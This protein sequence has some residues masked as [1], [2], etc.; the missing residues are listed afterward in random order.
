MIGIRITALTTGAAA[1]DTPINTGVID[2]GAAR[3]AVGHDVTTIAFD[4]LVLIGIADSAARAVFIT[5]ALGA[6]IT[7]ASIRIAE[8][9]VSTGQI[10]TAGWCFRTAALG[11]DTEQAIVTRTLRPAGWTTY[12]VGI[13]AVAGRTI[14]PVLTP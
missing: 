1:L 12:A 2:A 14:T 11:G 3:V 10:G 6:V 4:A 13:T 8:P 5:N 7:S 9:T